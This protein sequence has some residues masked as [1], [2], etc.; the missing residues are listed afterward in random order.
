[1]WPRRSRVRIPFVAPAPRPA[2]TPVDRG[3]I[4]PA[5]IAPATT[6]RTTTAAAFDDETF[7]QPRFAATD[8]IDDLN[9]DLNGERPADDHVA[10]GAHLQPLLA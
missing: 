8:P 7:E 9:G 1:M 6:A 3:G 2:R 4:A 10:V 5:T